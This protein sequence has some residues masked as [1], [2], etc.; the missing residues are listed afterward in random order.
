MNLL[1]IDLLI[2]KDGQVMCMHDSDL[3]RLCGNEFK[4]KNVA[5]Y[6]YETL[7]VLQRQYVSDTVNATYTLR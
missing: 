5:D 6:D 2:T 4:G 7:P 1:E 3:G